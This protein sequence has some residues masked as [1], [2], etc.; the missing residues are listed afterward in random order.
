MDFVLQ[1]KEALDHFNAALKLNPAPEEAQAALYNKAC[2]HAV[3]SA[4]PPS[5]LVLVQQGTF[6]GNVWRSV[7]GNNTSDCRTRY[8]TLMEGFVINQHLN[9]S[10]VST[11][12]SG[13]AIHSVR[14]LTM[15]SSVV[16]S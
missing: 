5:E 9:F 15:E 6:I 14:P 8:F 11:R 13:N 2:C 16:T 3:R 7:T 10:T 4:S 12:S 1:V